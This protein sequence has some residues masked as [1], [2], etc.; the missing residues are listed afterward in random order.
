MLCCAES[1]L[2]GS[3]SFQTYKIPTLVPI[4]LAERRTSP[5]NPRVLGLFNGLSRL[6]AGLRKLRPFLWLF[7]PPRVEGGSRTAAWCEIVSLFMFL[8]GVHNRRII[9][10]SLPVPVSTFFVAF[11]P[12]LLPAIW[13]LHSPVVIVCEL[14]S[15]TGQ[16]D[17]SLY[18]LCLHDQTAFPRLT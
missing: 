15:G 17:S 2:L 14:S 5:I 1:F 18:T 16:S 3:F 8:H 11:H 10:G 12:I 6:C 7:S 4:F 13:I 9:T